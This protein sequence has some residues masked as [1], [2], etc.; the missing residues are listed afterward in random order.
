MRPA[1]EL[2]PEGGSYGYVSFRSFR[3]QAE[4]LVLAFLLTACARATYDTHDDL[5]I[6]TEVK[7]ALLADR[8]LG[9]QQ[10]DAK[11]DH[12][13][14]T[15]IGTVKDRPQADRAVSIA[16][17]VR[18]VRDVRNELHVQLPVARSQLPVTSFRIG[19]VPSPTPA[20]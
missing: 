5:T 1:S 4:V 10:I 17:K 6:S 19:S 16:R 11:T 15:L 18:G 2:P 3:L 8:E 20:I 9:A 7:I 12:G 13:V 14:V